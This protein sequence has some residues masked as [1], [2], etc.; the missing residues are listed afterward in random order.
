MRKAWRYL[1]QRG[2]QKPYIEGET[3]NTTVKRKGPKR[4]TMN[5]KTLRRKIK[6]EQHELN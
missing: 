2:N 6:I 1:Y 3:D 5:Y 4:Q